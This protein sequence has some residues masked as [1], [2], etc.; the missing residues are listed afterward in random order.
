M[1]LAVLWLHIFFLVNTPF[2]CRSSRSLATNPNLTIKC[3]LT[4]KTALQ[5]ALLTHKNQNEQDERGT[6]IILTAQLLFLSFLAHLNDVVASR[7]HTTQSNVADN[8]T[9]VSWYTV[10]L[11]EFSLPW[12]FGM[13]WIIF[14]VT[15]CQQE[16]RTNY[17]IAMLWL[18]YASMLW[19]ERAFD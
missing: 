13:I 9:A 12:T 7:R 16:E 14:F 2:R 11:G 19:T 10:L 8:K 3:W 4:A 6:K 15:H 5:V 18:D 17:S 1:S